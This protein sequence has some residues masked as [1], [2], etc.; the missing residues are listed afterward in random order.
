MTF[1]VFSGTLNPTHFFTSR[2][3]LVDVIFVCSKYQQYGDVMVGMQLSL[4][5]NDM[6]VVYVCSCCHHMVQ[7]CASSRHWYCAVAV[8]R[9]PP[10]S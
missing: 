8:G 6:Q 4:Y 7:F 9:C 2:C 5:H 3:E 1:N 10:T